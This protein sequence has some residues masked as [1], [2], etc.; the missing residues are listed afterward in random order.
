[1]RNGENGTITKYLNLSGYR[2]Q[3]ARER[4]CEKVRARVPEF[5]RLSRMKDRARERGKRGG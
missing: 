1:M 4:V 2:G 3:A 5:S